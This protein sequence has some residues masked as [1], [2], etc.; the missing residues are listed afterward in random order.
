MELNQELRTR[1]CI[2]CKKPF[3]MKEYRG[4]GRW[5]CKECMLAKVNNESK[6]KLQI[7]KEAAMGCWW[8]EQYFMYADKV[9]K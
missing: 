8:L 6:R 4:R 2:D 5:D 9:L 1:N 7:N 3:P